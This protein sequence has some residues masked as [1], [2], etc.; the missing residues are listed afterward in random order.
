MAIVLRYFLIVLLLTKTA[1]AQL[2]GGTYWIDNGNAY[3]AIDAN[4][5]VKTTMPNREKT[6]LATSAQLTPKGNTAPLAVRS[7]TMSADL[8]KALLFTNAQ[9]VWRYDT[10]G[11]YWLFDKTTN[12]LK[13]LGA[14]LSEASLMF[15]K[16]SP[17]GQKVAYVSKNNVYVEDLKTAKIKKL[18][19]DN[20]TKKLINGTFDWAYE[21]EFDL[22]DGFRWSPDSRQIAFWQIDANKIRD[23]YMINNTDSTY[24]FTV[25][26]EYPKVGESPSACRIG[27]VNIETGKT[28]FMKVP[29]DPQQHYITQMEWADNAKE[30][31]IQQLNRKQNQSKIMYCEVA[32]GNTKSIWEETDATWIDAKDRWNNNDPAGWYWLKGGQAFLWVSEKDGWRHIYSISRDGK[33]EIKLTTGD[34]DAISIACVDEASGYVYFMASPNNATERYLYRTNLDGKGAPELLS[35]ADLKGTHSYSISPN[36]AFAQHSFSNF[37][38]TKRGGWVSLPDHKALPGETA[39]VTDM[40][41]RAPKVEF[42]KI[43]IEEGVEADAWMVKPKNFDPVKKYPLVLLVYGEPAT[44][45]V[46]N[47]FGVGMNGL[48][49]G[50]MADDGYIYVSIDN[51]GTPAP[52]GRAWR[53]AIYR[54][55]G[56]LNIQDLANGTKELLKLPYVDADRVAVHGWS[57]GGSSTLNLMFQ[58][59]DIFKVGISVAAVGDQ[60]S[61]DN[62]Y[63]ERYMGVPQENREDFVKGSPVTHAK[64]LKGKLLY[65]HGTGDDNVHYQNAEL[66]V[67]EL[68]KHNKVFQFMPYPNR[69]HSISEGTGTRTH[70]NNLFTTFLKENCPPGGK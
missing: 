67:N 12:S 9:R 19:S 23:F 28:Q 36:G 41:A 20:N 59:P 4:Q 14:S 44:Q 27:V 22:R 45:T 21:E 61:Y 39:Q 58:Y 46:Q 2:G 55:I 11:D 33:Q 34:Y 47:R 35:P 13:K 18:T 38:S 3:V 15:A 54:Q 42:L 32:N 56:R 48:Y 64:N 60:L 68:I 24:S 52:R 5:L 37:N 70:L 40:G 10:R 53:K 29:G 16:L 66:L 26:V 43:K 1:S 65:I 7:F 6:T 69:S 63:Q 62:I 50:N 51:R 25:P 49:N 17:D 31:V 57:G 8:Q 30:L